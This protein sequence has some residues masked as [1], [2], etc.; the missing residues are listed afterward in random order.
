M[1]LNV[2]KFHIKLITAK[3]LFCLEVCSDVRLL[4]V[5]SIVIFNSSTFSKRLNCDI[6]VDCL[7]FDPQKY[8]SVV[9]TLRNLTN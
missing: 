8:W 9:E 5:K 7:R 4:L 3:L 1:L 6:I 2:V